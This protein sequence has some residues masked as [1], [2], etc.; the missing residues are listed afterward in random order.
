MG[1]II[2]MRYDVR[3]QKEQYIF[4][5][6][7]ED[8]VYLQSGVEYTNFNIKGCSFIKERDNL[9]YSLL[10]NVDA[11]IIER[12]EE[13]TKALVDLILYRFPD[14]KIVLLD[15][16]ASLFWE[17]SRVC[18]ADKE[19]LTLEH[20]QG[21]RMYIYSDTGDVKDLGSSGEYSLVYSSLQVMQS[22][23]WCRKRVFLGELNEDKIILL[24]EFSGKNAGMGD[25]V[26]S[27]QQYICLAKQRGWY[28]VVYLT[29]DNQYI[30]CKGENMWD[31]YFEQPSGIS[32]EEALQSK[33]VIRG[34]E[35]NFGVLPWVAN[36]LCNMNEALKEKVFLNKKMLKLFEE[37]MPKQLKYSHKILGV[38]A[39]GSDLARCTH[40]KLDIKKMIEE[41]KGTFEKGYKYIF[42][43]T[44]DEEYQEFFYEEFGEQLLYIPQKRICHDYE[45]EEYK[46]VADLLEIKKEKRADWGSKYLLITYCL[47]KSDA[48]LY[49]I[50]CGALRLANLWRDKP[51]DMLQCTF[52][53]V[54]AL[55]MSEQK[56]VIHIYECESFLQQNSLVIVYGLGD[57][58]QMIYPLL[59]NY[60]DKIIA[61]DKRAAYEDYEFHGI[62]VIAPEKL[63]LLKSNAN[64]LITSPRCGQEIRKELEQMGIEKDRIVQLDY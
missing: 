23:C 48:L 1:L 19:Q 33:C 34:S 53:A 63:V 8:K 61:C 60:R 18:C 58:A 26:I 52:R 54:S 47:S 28:P 50:P 4:Q 49:S 57:V 59:D 56:G 32:V 51:Y 27:V 14:K 45:N 2:A 9:D 22:L 7:I 42:L 62:K 44:E 39:R 40:L 36:P 5:K 16:G 17:E 37:T 35:N 55:E 3:K 29:E 6:E 41:V 12:V 38:I 25:L 46:Y 13:Y 15:E 20:N 11:F 30:S 24:I 43:A 31:Y 21:L 10:E 64:I